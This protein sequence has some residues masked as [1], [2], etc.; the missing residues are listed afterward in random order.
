MSVAKL[1]QALCIPIV[2]FVSPPARPALCWV[3]AVLRETNC[4]LATPHGWPMRDPCHFLVAGKG[5]N[6]GYPRHTKWVAKEG[7]VYKM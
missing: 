7:R 1:A 4:T 6:I 5:C 2:Y 3:V